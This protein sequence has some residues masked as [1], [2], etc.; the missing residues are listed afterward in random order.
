MSNILFLQLLY[1][2][3]FSRTSATNCARTYN[4]ALAG[5]LITAMEEFGWKFGAK[6]A[7]EHVWDGFV[8]LSL[9]R[10][11]DRRDLCMQV[12]HTGSQRDRFTQLMEERNAWIIGEGQDEVSHYCDK[13]MRVYVGSDGQFSELQ[14]PGCISQIFSHVI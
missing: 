7:T 12:P 13:C 8:I 9:L 14:T 1:P 2:H 3:Y 11:H 5:K 6:L 4:S 10:D